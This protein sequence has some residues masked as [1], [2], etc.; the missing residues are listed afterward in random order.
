MTRQYLLLATSLAGALIGMA[1][2]AQAQAQSS[3]SSSGGVQVGEV[4]VTAQRRAE[5][6]ID[7]PITVAVVT[8]AQLTQRGVTDTTGLQ[9]LT[10]GIQMDFNGSFLAPAIRGISAAVTSQTVPPNVATYVD[11]VYQPS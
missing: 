7:V 6:L 8:G 11:G 4:V 3:T 2:R 5:R 1:D 9:K 10:S